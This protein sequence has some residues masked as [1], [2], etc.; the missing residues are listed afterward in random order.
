MK[1]TLRKIRVTDLVVLVRRF[2]Q[3]YKTSY[4]FRIAMGYFL[5]TNPDED[6]KREVL[7]TELKDILGEDLARKEVDYL[8]REEEKR[9]KDNTSICIDGVDYKVIESDIIDPFDRMAA[10]KPGEAVRF[11]DM[12]MYCT[13]SGKARA[14]HADNPSN[15][16]GA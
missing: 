2:S 9:E 11:Y 7:Y 8:L 13:A 14:C 5:S 10:L 3:A 15:N 1:E 16:W 6:E 12:Y 4:A